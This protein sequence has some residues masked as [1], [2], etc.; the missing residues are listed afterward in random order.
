MCVYSSK[1]YFVDASTKQLKSHS[2]S[3]TTSV[4]ALT[5]QV[6]TDNIFGLAIQGSY[7]YVSVWNQ[8]K[9]IKVHTGGSSAQ[10]VHQNLGF[11]AM[12]SLVYFAQQQAGKP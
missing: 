3:T 10:V 6:G 12:F 9:I 11:D 4:K 8:G 5:D 2:G 7:A 1:L